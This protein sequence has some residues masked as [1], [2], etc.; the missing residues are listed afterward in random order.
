MTLG[1]TGSGEVVQVRMIVRQFRMV[2]CAH[3]GVI[4][5]PDPGCQKGGEQCRAG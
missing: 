3:Q 2:M 5:L 1:R 4:G